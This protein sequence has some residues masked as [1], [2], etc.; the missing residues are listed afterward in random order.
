M[1]PIFLSLLV[2]GL[3]ACGARSGA[4]AS[5]ANLKA[6]SETVEH[7]VMAYQPPLSTQDSVRVNDMVVADH[8]VHDFGTIRTK[9][10]PVSCTFTLTN[11]SE[12]DI[13]IFEVVAS[14]GCTDVKWT[15]KT[16]PPGGKGTITATYKNSDGPYPFDKM[17]TAYISG[18][19]R[20]VVLRL[21]GV[22][23]KK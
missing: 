18:M 15:R 10:G 11:V 12:Q 5:A 14:C 19:E 4:D 16:I 7:P 9:D 22:V 23:R 3:C 17:L 2:L 8:T 1:K 6:L 21:R 20:P 13:V